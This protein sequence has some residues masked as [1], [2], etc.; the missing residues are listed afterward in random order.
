MATKTL[1]KCPTCGYP[2]SQPIS[3][4]QAAVCAYCDSNLIAQG[5]TIPTWL[6]A[7]SVG[8]LIGIVVGP[9]ILG[10]TEEGSKWL[11]RQAT[12]RLK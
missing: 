11:Q 12:K 8:L 9:A 10:S 7:A 2:I 6:F 5:V 3:E 4:G 1:S